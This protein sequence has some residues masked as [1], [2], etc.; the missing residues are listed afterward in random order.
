MVSETIDDANGTVLHYRTGKTAGTVTISPAELLAS[1][2]RYWR[3]PLRPGE[4][5]IRIR[6]RI[7]EKW[8]KAGV[9]SEHSTASLLPP[10]VRSFS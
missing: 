1:P 7:E 9:P 6:V 3:Q 4:I 8:F 2:E 10:L 5:A